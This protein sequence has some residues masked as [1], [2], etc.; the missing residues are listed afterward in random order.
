MAAIQEQ[1]AHEADVADDRDRQ[2]D[3]LDQ[4]EECESDALE[5]LPNDDPECN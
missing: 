4:G 1:P 2:Q 3:D 5:Y